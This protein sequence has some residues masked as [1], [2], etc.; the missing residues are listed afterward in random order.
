MTP[1]VRGHVCVSCVIASSVRPSVNPSYG[2]NGSTASRAPS[3]H[4]VRDC[5]RRTRVR[6]EPGAG[7]EREEAIAALVHRL[8][9]PRHLRLVA[10]RHAADAAPRR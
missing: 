5:R 2:P 6:R 8:D 1:M 4:D 3:L 7:A 9:E 10:E